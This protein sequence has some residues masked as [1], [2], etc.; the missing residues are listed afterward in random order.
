MVA[1]TQPKD[2]ESSPTIHEYT[3]SQWCALLRVCI[4]RNNAMVH[5]PIMVQIVPY[6]CMFAPTFAVRPWPNDDA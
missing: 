1:D 5:A 3:Y 6:L 2:H 4:Y